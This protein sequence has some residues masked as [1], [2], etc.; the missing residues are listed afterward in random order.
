M[1]FEAESTQEGE[2]ENVVGKEQEQEQEY[3]SSPT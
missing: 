3:E 1:D 2:E